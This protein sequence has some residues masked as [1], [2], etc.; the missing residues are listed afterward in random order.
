MD[1]LKTNMN[2]TKSDEWSAAIMECPKTMAYLQHFLIQNMRREKVRLPNHRRNCM[3]RKDT[4]SPENQ[5][6]VY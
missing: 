3:K 4:M 6:K 1:I 2:I 5:R